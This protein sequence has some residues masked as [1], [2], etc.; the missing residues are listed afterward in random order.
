M[1]PAKQ[2]INAALNDLIEEHLPTLCPGPTKDKISKALSDIL[3]EHL[4]TFCAALVEDQQNSAL[5][6]PPA[7]QAYIVKQIITMQGDAYLL[8]QTRIDT[9]MIG[10]YCSKSWI[11][12]APVSAAS[13][14]PVEIEFS[15]M[16]DAMQRFDQLKNTPCQGSLFAAH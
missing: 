4:P 3:T 5:D 14:E 9:D 16:A 10:E 12:R 1:T 8:Q 6:T 2:K 11:I 7:K 13:S 15:S